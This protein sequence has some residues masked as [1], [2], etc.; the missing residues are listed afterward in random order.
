M[1]SVGNILIKSH[2]NRRLMRK[3]A[4]PNSVCLHSI[5]AQ[6]FNPLCNNQKIELFLPFK[7]L[8]LPLLFN[9]LLCHSFLISAQWEGGYSAAAGVAPKIHTPNVPAF[10]V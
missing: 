2:V 4:A 7:L 6:A 8:T 5:Q 10:G 9:A 1:F 3:L